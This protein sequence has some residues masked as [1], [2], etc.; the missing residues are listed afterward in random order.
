MF[1]ILKSALKT[2]FT[3]TLLKACNTITLTKQSHPIV[4]LHGLESSS[5]KM[6]VSVKFKVSKDY[7]SLSGIPY[8]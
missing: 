6:I 5:E 3:L 1:Y 2:L 4:V 7:E 8:H